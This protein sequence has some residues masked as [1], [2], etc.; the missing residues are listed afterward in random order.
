MPFQGLDVLTIFHSLPSLEILLT[1]ATISDHEVIFLTAAH[2][3][4]RQVG[5]AR[6]LGSSALKVNDQIIQWH[7]SM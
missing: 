7:L 6:P 3:K 4:D 1:I 5:S 2:G